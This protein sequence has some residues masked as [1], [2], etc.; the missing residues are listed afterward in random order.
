MR[1]WI[2][3][4]VVV[5]AVY[6]CKQIVPGYHITVDLEESEGKWIKL[7]TREAGTYVTFDS[8]LVTGD[9]PGV[10]QGSVEGVTT[11]Y[12]SVEEVQGSIQLLVENAT[13]TI[14]GTME[15]PVI[16]STSKAQ[17]DLNAY[18]EQIKP[19]TVQLTEMANAIRAARAEESSAKADSLIEEY[20]KVFEKQDELDSIFIANHPSSF[21]SVIILRSSY[22]S[23]DIVQLENTLSSLDAAL[24][25]M[26]E[27]KHMDGILQRMK[28]VT[29]GQSYTD[30][31]LATPE[32]GT[33]SVSDVHQGNVL[34][35]DFWAAWC[36]PCRRANPEVVEI[37]QAYHDRGFEILGV[38]LDRDSARWVQAIADD[39]LT[40]HHISDLQYWNSKGA[41]LYGV[42]SIP[43]TVLIDREGII[44]AKN[45]HGDKLREAI[46]SLL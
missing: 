45:L 16:E 25:Q 24:R 41:E 44:Q 32:G 46:E 17:G 1:K 18:N 10:L 33:L 14:N 30:F 42:S 36:G 37:Y 9:A 7:L 40:W 11:M 31:E 3:I 26:D 39:Q 13:Y 38:S 19:V 4:A 22:H 5:L 20:Y 34:M 8:T 6:G 21:A 2:L 29:I 27:Y 15:A 23:M 28:A 35:I 43:H 12:L